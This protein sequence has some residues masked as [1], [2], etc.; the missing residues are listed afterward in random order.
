MIL[1][2][3]TVLALLAL[4]L[5]ACSRQER[6]VGLW[7]QCEDLTCTRP[8]GKAFVFTNDGLTYMATDGGDPFDVPKGQYCRTTRPN[9]TYEIQGRDIVLVFPDRTTQRFPFTVD[10]Q[11]LTME[12]AGHSGETVRFKRMMNSG[13]LPPTC[14]N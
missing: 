13:E 1:R 7:E 3:Q 14:M 8:L 4:P 10:K 5:A 11:F 12:G 6:L 2:L 9:S